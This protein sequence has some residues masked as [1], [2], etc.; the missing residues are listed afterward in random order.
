VVGLVAPVLYPRPYEM[1][2]ALAL[3]GFLGFLWI[4][5]HQSRFQALWALGALAAVGAGL[6]DLV[7][8]ARKPGLFVRDAFGV[9][10]VQEFHPFR[11]MFHGSTLHGFMDSR[12]PLRP[13]SYYGPDSGGGRAI[14]MLMEERPAL[15]VGVVGMGV[16]SFGG[17]G[18]ASDHYTFYEISPLVARLSGPGPAPVFPILQ[19]SPA[20]V[21]VVLGD[22]RTELERELREQGPR[23]FD[24]LV[25]DAFSGDA[26]PWHL[27]TV[28]AVQM[29]LRHLAPSGILA[30]HVSNRM[31]VHRV[32]LQTCM[33][34]NLN[35]SVVQDTP[36]KETPEF[37]RSL[38]VLV[39][40]SP[41]GFFSHP[42]IRSS[43]R[44]AFG[45]DLSPESRRPLPL[46]RSGRPWRDDHAA[47]SD[48]LIENR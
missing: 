16:G 7:Q 20:R 17:W 36:K 18:R 44:I 25:V 12:S 47:L 14:R 26:V 23:G 27:L 31:P 3:A 39:S 46:L 28:E 10:H 15:K 24:L 48:L 42:L 11:V 8:I 30:L 13:T 9:I 1:G 4:R 35:G 45:P 32:A 22:A 5:S 6:H 41:T 37:S 19:Q 43:Y 33:A 2:V 38:Y 21:E 40:M 34:L 29:Y